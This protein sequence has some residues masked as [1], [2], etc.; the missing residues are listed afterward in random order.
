VAFS[1][2]GKSLV[3]GGQTGAAGE[4]SMWEVGTGKLKHALETG[5][6]VNAVAFSPD[7]TL[8]AAATGGETVHVWDVA[9]GEEVVALKG[10]SGWHGSVAFAPDGRTVAAG[11]SDGKVR[12]WDA[13]TGELLATLKGHGAEVFAVAIAPDGKTLASTGQDQTVR[14]WPISRPAAGRK[15]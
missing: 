4:V 12:L 3:V 15:E 13:R 1:P 11:G 9:K 14:L 2:D 10:S 7:G 8:V 5:K 6:Y